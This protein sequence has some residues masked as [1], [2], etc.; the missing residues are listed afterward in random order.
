MTA[1][2]CASLATDAAKVEGTSLQEAALEYLR[3]REN[4]KVTS[5]SVKQI[6]EDL[7]TKRDAAYRSLCEAL[8][9]AEYDSSDPEDVSRVIEST[10][11]IDVIEAG[12]SGEVPAGLEHGVETLQ[13][14]LMENH[15]DKD[16]FRVVANLRDMIQARNT[17]VMDYLR[18]RVDN[19]NTERVEQI[20]EELLDRTGSEIIGAVC[21]DAAG[22]WSPRPHAVPVVVGARSPIRENETSI[23]DYLNGRTESPRSLELQ[24][25]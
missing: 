21:A 11:T 13:A 18:D 3:D 16:P 8:S 1:F 23:D 19:P 22:W 24:T 14:E 7:L 4:Q 6:A 10:I 2:L 20:Y 25:V 17:T 15:T 9:E 12:L 5:D